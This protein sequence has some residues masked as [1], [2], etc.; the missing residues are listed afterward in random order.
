MDKAIKT[1][2]SIAFFVFG[3]AMLIIRDLKY[4][5]SIP[6][7]ISQYFPVMFY[8]GIIFMAVGYYLK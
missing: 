4:L 7:G 8:L 1:Q 6:L 3:F 5:E 2:F